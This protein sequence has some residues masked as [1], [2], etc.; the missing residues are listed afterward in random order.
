MAPGRCQE[1]GHHQDA[2]DHLSKAAS[3]WKNDQQHASKDRAGDPSKGLRLRRMIRRRSRSPRRHRI[4]G[5]VSGCHT[6]Q[7]H[8]GVREG[9]DQGARRGACECH[10]AIEP[11]HRSQADHGRARAARLDGHVGRQR[12]EV[13]VRGIAVD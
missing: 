13:E 8:R 1:H 12:R 11:I 10:R 6:V 4:D 9:T 2:D 5:D 3:P 7:V